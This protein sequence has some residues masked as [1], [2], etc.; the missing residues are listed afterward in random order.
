[1]QA[2]CSHGAQCLGIGILGQWLDGGRGSWQVQ[3]STHA[4][5]P[6]HLDKALHAQLVLPCLE[7]A[8]ILTLAITAA[9]MLRSVPIPCCRV[10]G[11][12]REG[13]RLR[14]GGSTPC[15]APGHAA[16]CSCV[17]AT[18]LGLR[19]M[20]VIEGT[21]SAA[22][23]SRAARCAGAARASAAGQLD[24]CKEGAN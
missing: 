20:R 19:C 12:V 7:Q 3:V 13:G 22:R 17:P 4:W 23:P 5:C 21:T 6:Q 10:G 9:D 18:A 8:L 15:C 16:R 24:A 2:V 14:S 11:W 1:M